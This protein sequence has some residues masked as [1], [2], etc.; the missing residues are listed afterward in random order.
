MTESE[1]LSMQQ[2][3]EKFSATTDPSH[4]FLADHIS[5]QLLQDRLELVEDLWG[6]WG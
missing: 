3:S 6:R 4:I 2:K 5:G 1:N